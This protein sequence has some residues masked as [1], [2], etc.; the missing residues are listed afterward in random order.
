VY[1]FLDV[2]E[3]NRSKGPGQIDPHIVILVKTSK[4]IHMGLNW[5]WGFFYNPNVRVNLP[6]AG[7]RI[8]IIAGV[9]I[10][11]GIY[12]NQHAIIVLVRITSL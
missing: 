9:T 5:F 12:F 2:E 8:F 7:A 6:L 4:P 10:A 1:L 11:N 3:N